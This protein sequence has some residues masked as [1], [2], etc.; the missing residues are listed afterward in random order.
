MSEVSEIRVAPLGTTGRS[1]AG[2]EDD[3][4]LLR[5]IGAISDKGVDL[6]LLPQ[7]SFSLYFPAHRD[8]KA[9][10]L[11]ERFPSQRMAAARE[12]AGHV[13][14]AA[15]AYECVGEGVFYV[16]G[17]LGTKKDGTVLA[18][19]QHRV[20]AAPGRFEQMFFSPGHEERTVSDLPWGGTAL[21]L[22]A[23]ARD[24]GAWADLA[25]RG[26]DLILVSVGEDTD[27]WGAV[28]R[29]CQG[30]SV[31][32]G[33]SVCAVNRASADDEPVFAG[34]SFASDPNGN[35]ITP[36]G[37]GHYTI[38]IPKTGSARA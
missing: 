35:E 24:P 23:D 17:E 34:G 36:D 16:S 30:F 15:S 19:R 21:L 6:I 32:H 13:W 20:E 37:N 2:G 10:E 11:G 12:A 18:Q 4:V 1:V 33:V 22:G 25:R 14:L 38:S 29:I 8:R 28:T 31:V 26:A 3:G 7:L 5:E 9:L 27:G